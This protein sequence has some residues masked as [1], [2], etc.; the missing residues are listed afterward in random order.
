MHISFN[1]Y[2]DVIVFRVMSN[3]FGFFHFP[4]KLE[5]IFFPLIWETFFFQNQKKQSRQNST[6]GNFY[7]TNFIQKMTSN[8][9]IEDMHNIML[10]NLLF[11]LYRLFCV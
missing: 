9:I 5:E 6:G 4:K 2:I 1:A 3:I 10:V 7:F 11:K 8:K